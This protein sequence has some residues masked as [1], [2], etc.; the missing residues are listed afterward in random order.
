M[1][2][3]WRQNASKWGLCSVSGSWPRGISTLAARI[4]GHPTLAVTNAEQGAG[5]SV[6]IC[7]VPPVGD[8]IFFVPGFPLPGHP[9]FPYGIDVEPDSF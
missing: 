2:S 6:A 9:H 4:I 3:R 7:I 8:N 5:L 1:E